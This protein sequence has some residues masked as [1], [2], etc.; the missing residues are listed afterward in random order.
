MPH[1]HQELKKEK[2]KET[3]TSVDTLTHTHTQGAGCISAALPW[4]KIKHEFHTEG[5]SFYPP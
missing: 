3:N 2:R 4:I 1:T 5:M